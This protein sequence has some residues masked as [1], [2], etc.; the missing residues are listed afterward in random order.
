[1]LR[2]TAV[3]VVSIFVFVALLRSKETLPSVLMDAL[4]EVPS[5]KSKP[6]AKEIFLALASAA[7][8]AR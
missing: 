2:P 3:T 7:L 8:L 1:M 6:L 5:T 4:V